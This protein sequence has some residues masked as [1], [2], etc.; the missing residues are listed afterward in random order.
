[1]RTN[2]SRKENE[3]SKVPKEIDITPR[4]PIQM[5]HYMEIIW[6]FI[7]TKSFMTKTLDYYQPFYQLKILSQGHEQQGSNF[8]E[9][10]QFLKQVHRITLG[11]FIRH[12][13][14]VKLTLLSLLSF[15]NNSDI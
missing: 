5:E 6:R 12:T 2:A 10:I 4:F 14:A 9:G 11:I 1:M 3:K 13:Q 7:W 8:V 15:I